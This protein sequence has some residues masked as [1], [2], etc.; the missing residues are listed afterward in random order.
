MVTHEEEGL[1][2]LIFLMC[3]WE[4]HEMFP[5]PKTCKI[6]S[7]ANYTKKAST[8]WISLLQTTKGDPIS[9]QASH[10]LK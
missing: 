5:I 7:N 2:I 1:Q 4:L 9:H 3:L 8:S 10:K 6:W